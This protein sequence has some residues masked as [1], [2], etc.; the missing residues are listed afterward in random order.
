M[1][2]LILMPYTTFYQHLSKDSENRCKCSVRP[3]GKMVL[4]TIQR[5]LKSKWLEND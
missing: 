3:L 5:E 1:V 2:I 4:K